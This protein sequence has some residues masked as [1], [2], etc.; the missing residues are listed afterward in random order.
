MTMVRCLRMIIVVI[1]T[2]T[3]MLMMIATIP[4][5]KHTR[6]IHDE[7][8]D[9]NHDRLFEC[10]VNRIHQPLETFPGHSERKEYQQYR[11]RKSAQGIHFSGTKIKRGIACPTPCIDI[12]EG[13][14]SERHG[15]RPHMQAIRQQSHGP[16]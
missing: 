6:E 5:D 10:D 12:R 9:G 3:G 8:D 13:V 2:L 4:Q 16:I 7:P 1:S 15:V 11:T 14:D